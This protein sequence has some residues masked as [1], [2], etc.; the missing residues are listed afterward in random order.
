MCG[1]GV[2]RPFPGCTLC[3]DNQLVLRQDAG[4]H[5]APWC[6]LGELLPSVCGM[7]GILPVLSGALCLVPGQLDHVGYLFPGMH[8][9]VVVCACVVRLLVFRLLLIEPVGVSTFGPPL[10]QA[11]WG[12]RGPAPVRCATCR[13][14]TVPVVAGELGRLP[15]ML[16]A[17]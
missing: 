11:Q 4:N 12:V 9:L 15:R 16:L 2:T 17:S 1:P 10:G 13:S 3:M 7:L 8:L 6:V 14:D 5:H